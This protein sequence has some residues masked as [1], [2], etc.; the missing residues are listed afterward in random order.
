MGK[1]TNNW[2]EVDKDG[3]GRALAA[4]GIEFAIGELL[5]NAW[6]ADGVTTVAV[7]LTPVPHSPS[8][9]LRVEDDSPTGF[10]D[11]G[12]AYRLFGGSTK[13]Q[14]PSKRGKWDLGEK[15]VFALARTAQVASTTGTVTFDEKGRHVD[16]VAKRERGSVVEALLPMTRDD[17][18]R[19]EKFIKQLVPPTTVS[20]T[21]NG[22]PIAYRPV[23][24]TVAANLETQIADEDGKL[25]KTWRVCDVH[26]I[27]LRDG[28]KGMLY[29][30]GLPVQ[31]TG[32]AYHYDIQ[33]RTPVGFDRDA[34]SAYYLN[35]V[36][37]AVLDQLAGEIEDPAADWV[38]RAMENGTSLDTVKIIIRKRFGDKAVAADPTDQEAVHKAT[39]AGYTVVHGGSLPASVW[40]KVRQADALPRAGRIFPTQPTTASVADEIPAAEWTDGMKRVVRYTQRVGEKLLGFEPVVRIVRHLAGGYLASWSKENTGSLT[41]NAGALSEDWWPKNGCITDENVELVIH[42]MGHCKPKGSDGLVGG[43]IGNHLSDEYYDNLCRLGA[44][45]RHH[46]SLDWE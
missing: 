21:Y 16:R 19:C 36:R 20:T 3:L 17:F 34:V 4:R 10:N 13:G 11:L 26:V 22:I 41:F 12:H 14:D 29:E 28:E 35:T 25:R 6:D 37:R 32:D 18:A 45:L 1:R 7:S 9:T 15:L 33:Q 38:D 31:E 27:A 40:E 23:L 42:E 24:H 44:R 8:A 2:F 43:V 5:Q 30:L 46:A 39:A